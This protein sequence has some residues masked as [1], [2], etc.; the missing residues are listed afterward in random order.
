MS[1]APDIPSQQDPDLTFAFHNPTKVIHPSHMC[2][3]A[4]LSDAQNVSAALKCD[5]N[6][7]NVDALKVEI[8]VFFDLC[9]TE[10][11][12]LAK[13]F[14]KSEVKIKQLLSNETKY[15]IPKDPCTIASECVG[16]CQRYQDELRLVN[17]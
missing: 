8:D 10:I 12:Q 11:T 6:K 7:E 9:D 16:S 15:Q 5:I 13:K 14:N 3:G 1:N 4:K 17:A 2:L